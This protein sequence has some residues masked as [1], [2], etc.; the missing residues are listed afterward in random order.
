M[1]TWR[2]GDVGAAL[3]RLAPAAAISALTL[4]AA[5]VATDW[6]AAPAIGLAIGVWLVAGGLAYLWTRLQR[7]EGAALAKLAVL[8]LAVWSMSIAHVGAGV[9]TV[10]AVAETAFRSERAIA[11]APGSGIDFAGRRVTL[12][13]V[14]EIE[15]PNYD[16]TRAL[17]RVDNRGGSLPL[18]AER[19][20]YPTAP[21][22]TTEVGILSG[23]DGDL[24]VALG[25]PV[26]DGAGAWGVRL[27]HNPLVQ[28][29]FIGALM[30]AAGGLL[31][32]IALARRRKGAQ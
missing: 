29:I 18:S 28:L 11:L 4:A 8:P 30:M 26:R 3:V 21:A 25:E 17:F 13:D 20:F 19:R 24:Y 7:G 6:R 32:M 22:P 12:L 16:A 23:I 5:L 27:Y 15:G 10:G 1:L 2:V 31:S 9:L 14:I